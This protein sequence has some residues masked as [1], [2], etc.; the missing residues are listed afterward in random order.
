MASPASANNHPAGQ[1]AGRLEVDEEVLA[2]LARE[3]ADAARTGV[4]A[5]LLSRRFPGLPLTE[6]YRIQQ[7]NL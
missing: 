5:R 3:L 2:G 1:M 4:P 6:A 7:I